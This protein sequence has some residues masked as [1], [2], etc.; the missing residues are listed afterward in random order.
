MQVV[1]PSG[2]WTYILLLLEFFRGQ[3]GLPPVVKYALMVGYT[4]DDSLLNIIPD[5]TD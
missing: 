5:K 3:Y 1:A 4:D 2:P